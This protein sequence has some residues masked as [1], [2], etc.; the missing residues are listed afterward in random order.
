[1][2]RWWNR[3]GDLPDVSKYFLRLNHPCQRPFVFKGL[4][5][6]HGVVFAISYPGPAASAHRASKTRVIALAEALR[7][8]PQSLGYVVVV[9]VVA[10]RTTRLI[11]SVV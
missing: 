11:L 2:P 5:T 7:P 8:P 1:L 9:G 3:A 6:L 4:L 10:G